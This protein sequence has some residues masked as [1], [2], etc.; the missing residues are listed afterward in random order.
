[1]PTKFSSS[2]CA[3]C[4]QP[5]VTET[6]L[7]LHVQVPPT[8]LARCTNTPRRAAQLP[9]GSPPPSV[10]KGR[11]GRLYPHALRHHTEEN[12]LGRVSVSVPRRTHTGE[13]L[14]A[15]RPVLAV[16]DEG[17]A[18]GTV[19][20][21]T[22][23]GDRKREAGKCVGV[24][25]AG[26]PTLKWASGLFV[27]PAATNLRSRWRAEISGCPPA[28]STPVV[29]VWSVATL[30]AR[31]GLRGLGLPRSLRLARRTSCQACAIAR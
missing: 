15:R 23:A 25:C 26:D 7:A 31:R 20:Q 28:P 30:S 16:T 1:M 8:V 3:F 14:R 13:L 9:R 21:K 29:G 5:L 6:V 24:S 12:A 4:E 10:E 27:S 19:P 17:Q 22:G 11:R 2:P 18:T